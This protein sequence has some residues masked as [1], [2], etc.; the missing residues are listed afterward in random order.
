LEIQYYLQAIILTRFTEAKEEALTE[1]RL[2][3][4]LKHPNIVTLLK[5]NET[6]T[7]VNELLELLAGGPIYYKPKPSESADL[8]QHKIPIYPE[9]DVRGNDVV[10]DLITSS[11][12]EATL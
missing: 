11:Y 3:S 12:N 5:H 2:L 7:Y 6:P 1:I 4:K 9:S 8:V 10:L